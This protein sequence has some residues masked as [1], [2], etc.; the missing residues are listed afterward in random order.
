MY[1]SLTMENSI[2]VLRVRSLLGLNNL[3]EVFTLINEEQLTGRVMNGNY[4]IAL[5]A[6]LQSIMQSKGI[7]IT[8]EHLQRELSPTG[9]FGISFFAEDRKVLSSNDNRQRSDNKKTTELL[10]Q[11][12]RFH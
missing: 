4:M 7:D 10:D 11:D 5:D 12:L 3:S 1:W 2:S 8:L 9:H 6:K